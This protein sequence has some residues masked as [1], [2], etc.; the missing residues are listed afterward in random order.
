[1]KLCSTLVTPWT[2]AHQAPLSMRLSRQEYWSGLPLPSLADLP[3]PGIRLQSPA[4]Q[5][6]SLLPK[7]PGKPNTY[8]HTHAHICVYLERSVNLDMW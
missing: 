2:V 5:T 4:L 7:L 3:N 1:M 6:D 8:I